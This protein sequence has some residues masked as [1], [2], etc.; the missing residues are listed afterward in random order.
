MFNACTLACYRKSNPVNI[1][2]PQLK[3]LR[4]RLVNRK[5]TRTSQKR[6]T[7]IPCGPGVIGSP[8]PGKRKVPAGRTDTDL[9]AEYEIEDFDATDPTIGGLTLSGAVRIGP[10]QKR[11]RREDGRKEKKADNDDG[12]SQ[13][14]KPRPRPVPKKPAMPKPTRPDMQESWSPYHGPHG[15]PLEAPLQPGDP[16]Y[17]PELDTDWIREQRKLGN[18][19]YDPL[20]ETPSP[21]PPP[22][23]L[24]TIRGNANHVPPGRRPEASRKLLFGKGDIVVAPTDDTMDDALWKDGELLDEPLSGEGTK[25]RVSTRFSPEPTPEPWMIGAEDELLIPEPTTAGPKVLPATTSTFSFSFGGHTLLHAAPNLRRDDQEPPAGPVFSLRPADTGRTP[26][27]T[28]PDGTTPAAGTTKAFQG[29]SFA[30][31]RSGEIPRLEQ[32]PW[33]PGVSTVPKRSSWIPYLVH[34][35]LVIAGNGEFGKPDSTVPHPQPLP[36]GGSKGAAPARSKVAVGS[37]SAGGPGRGDEA[38][39]DAEQGDG[40]VDSSTNPSDQKKGRGGA[41]RG[42]GRGKGKSGPRAAKAPAS[43][44]AGDAPKPPAPKRKRKVPEP[45]PPRDNMRP[46]EHTNYSAMVG[47]K[48]RK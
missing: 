20:H 45:L 37:Q 27:P 19:K 23:L 33:V 39:C 21:S 3:P 25:G 43:A 32:S 4:Q 16:G 10:P 1:Q 17:D 34:G 22:S 44:P 46:K 11:S 36:A 41:R 28:M 40:L 6:T 7:R 35:S 31:I 24:P 26:V 5:K 2:T 30:P 18:K 38:E 42:R 9:G 12:S 47:I 29:F 15:E 8:A 48:R 13:P 14:A